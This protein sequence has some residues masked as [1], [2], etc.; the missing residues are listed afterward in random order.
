MDDGEF[1]REVQRRLIGSAAPSPLVWEMLAKYVAS[2]EFLEIR[3]RKTELG[4]MAHLFEYLGFLRVD[5]LNLVVLDDYRI[6]RSRENGNRKVKGVLVLTSPSTRNREVK[7]LARALSWATERNLI[8][9]NP[10][11]DHPDE[12]EPPGRQTNIT[13]DDVDKL[14]AGAMDLEKPLRTRLA[15]RAMISTKYDGILRRGEV[16]RMRWPML[17]FKSGAILLPQSETKAH[18]DT[19]RI[20]IFS[21]RAQ[22]DVRAMPRDVA[23]PSVFLTSRL[24][25]WHPR[26]FLNYLQKVGR[27][28][29][30]KGAEGENF[31]AHDLRAG[32]ASEQLELGTQERDVMDFAGWTT[33]AMIDRYNRRRGAAAVARAKARLE[34]SRQG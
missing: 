6:K 11:A 13:S 12:A 28:V 25:P 16:C 26:T 8:P 34:E 32:G 19:I 3:D 15:L 10:I 31:V 14:R 7:R 27:A 30:I 1:L 17:D 18:R 5:Q 24:R 21:D 4:R 23:S 22:E 9:K 33:R 20:T 2:P 29:G